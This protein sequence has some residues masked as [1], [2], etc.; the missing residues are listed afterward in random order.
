VAGYYDPDSGTLFIPADVDS[1]RLRSIVIPHELVHALQDQYLPLDSVMHQRHQN[2]R[3]A[4]GQAIFE[5]QA[6]LAQ[7]RIL[8]PEQSIENLPPFSEQRGAIAQQQEQFPS[9]SNA[10]LWLRETL[11]FPYL[12]G[13]DFVRW[14]DSSH[15]GKQ[16][17]G[18]L[19]PTSTAQ[20]LH[21]E[22]YA[23]HDQPIDLVFIHPAADGVRYDDDLGEFETRL[24]FEQLLGIEAQAEV[25][26]SGWAGDRYAVLGRGRTPPPRPGSPEGSSA[27][28]PSAPGPDSPPGSSH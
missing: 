14:F 5:G 6:T 12:G 13:A 21:P 8:M 7:L 22:R 3:R 24:L 10:P 18:A 4:A 20:I 9:F 17:Y 15:P 19:M 27:P 2:D 1:Q 11:V 16:P 28:G 25:L 23:A 26:A